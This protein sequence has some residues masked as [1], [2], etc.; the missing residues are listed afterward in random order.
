MFFASVVGTVLL[1]SLFYFALILIGYT[2]GLKDK[3]KISKVQYEWAQLFLLVFYIPLG[4]GVIPEFGIEA[5]CGMVV[6]YEACGLLIE[7]LGYFGK[8]RP[9]MIGHHTG[10]IVLGT[11]SY[12]YFYSVPLVERQFWWLAFSSASYLFDSNVFLQLRNIYRG[13]A[14]FDVGFALTFFYS[15]FYLQY[16]LALKFLKLYGMPWPEFPWS[17]HSTTIVYFMISCFTLLNIYWGVMIVLMVVKTM[18]KKK[19]KKKDM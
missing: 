13:N 5:L 3:N 14:F 15:R 19:R 17:Y 9:L 6:G 16:L 18:T 2:N 8:P 4:R 11:I 7:I 1:M 10:C 12:L